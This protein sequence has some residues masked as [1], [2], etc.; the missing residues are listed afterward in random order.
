MH[1]S[2]ISSGFYELL[3]K[4]ESRD[5][6]D[7]GGLSGSSGQRGIPGNKFNFFPSR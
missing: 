5:D 7:C 6:T 4:Y 2:K 3:L 1:A